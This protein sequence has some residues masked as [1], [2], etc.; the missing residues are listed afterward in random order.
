MRGLLALLWRHRARVALG[1]L[2]LL[3][4]DGLQMVSPLLVRHAIDGLVAGADGAWLPA[5]GLA[6]VGLAVLA[7]RYWWR[8]LVMGAARLVRFRLRSR[9][10]RRLVA[11]PPRWH[12]GHPAGDHLTRASSDVDAVANACGLGLIAAFDASMMTAMTVGA[13]L[14]L[15]PRLTLLALMP[16]LP[17]GGAVW[18]IGRAVHR[19]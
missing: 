19:R 15:D 18:W 10:H 8:V 13:M 2:A 11:L 17:L 12:A 4:V 16:L 5:L 6:A 3:V 7:G 1:L 14:W 9:L